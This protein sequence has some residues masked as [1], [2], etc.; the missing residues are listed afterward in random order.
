MEVDLEDSTLDDLLTA[1]VYP[2]VEPLARHTEKQALT[3]EGQ[4]LQVHLHLEGRHWSTTMA[5]SKR[6][7]VCGA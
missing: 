7:S 5:R 6:I 2:P 3:L 4:L 1:K